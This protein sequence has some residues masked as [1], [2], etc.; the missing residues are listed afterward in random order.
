MVDMTGGEVSRVTP[1]TLTE[2]FANMLA[3]PVIATNVLTRVKLH[4]GLQFRNQDEETLNEDKTTM[5]KQ[6]GN[7]TEEN[8][9]T[10]EYTL[11]PMEKLIEMEDIDLTKIKAFPFQTQINYTGL[12]GAKYCRVVTQL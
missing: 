9:F 2:N 3:K 11:K 5:A 12:D 6:L 10:F 8:E 1:S 7:V 4:K